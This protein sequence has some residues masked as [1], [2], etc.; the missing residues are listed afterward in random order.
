[1]IVILSERKDKT[2]TE[3]IKWLEYYNYK[4][5]RMNMEDSIQVQNVVNDVVLKI[6]DESEI[7]LSEVKSF[8][9]RRGFFNYHHE[10]EELPSALLPFLKEENYH[11]KNYYYYLLNKK[12]S[13][14]NIHS[15]VANK[16]VN[17]DLSKNVGLRIPKSYILSSKKELKKVLAKHKTI[18]KAIA[19]NGFFYLNDVDY[20]VMYTTVVKN[21]D[22]YSENFAPTYFQEY[23]EKRY[24]LRI[25]YLKGSF[26]SMAIF[27]Q[28][29]EQTQIDFRKYNK[30]KPN[31][32]VPY[33]LP[34]DIE[35]KLKELMEVMKLD[36]ASIDM[37]VNHKLEYYF[38]EVNPLGQFGM[39]SYPCNYY[40][41]EKVAQ[42]L[43]NYD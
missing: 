34:N 13:L 40:L 35:V 32:T 39:V 11:L 6:N 30:K 1:M 16:L 10:M 29:D 33:Q 9:Y 18:T 37:I 31:R 15:S 43:I 26:Y 3:V 28:R 24:E 27:S 42:T 22:D 7:H 12:N 4:W 8:W 20:G 2:T 21:A 25:F 14:G 36:T 38:L 17:N 19:G 23:I 41:E 5:T